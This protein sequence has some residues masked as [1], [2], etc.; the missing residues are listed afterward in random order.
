MA[1]FTRFTSTHGPPGNC[2]SV[3]REIVDTYTGKL[4]AQL[5]EH[6]GEIGWCSY[7]NGLIW[8]TNP[9][10]FGGILVDWLGQIGDSALA[11]A[12][13]AFGDL[14]YWHNGRVYYLDVLYGKVS[15]RTDKL[16]VFFEY[17][18]CQDDYCR[19]VLDQPLYEQAR[20]MLGVPA[21]DECYAFEPALALGGPGTVDTLRRVKLREHLAILSQLV[22]VNML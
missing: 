7:A 16:D 17:T 11:F 10:D 19:D 3:S 1:P 8:I 4:P 18:L 13:T 9:A 5:L 6:W 2:I 12:W 20:V 14:M 15:K 22:E 21:H